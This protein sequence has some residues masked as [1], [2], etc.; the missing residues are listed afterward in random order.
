MF[1]L[2]LFSNLDE[3]YAVQ[4]DRTEYGIISWFCQKTHFT[5]VFTSKI[6]VFRVTPYFRFSCI[7]NSFHKDFISCILGR[8]S[9]CIFERDRYPWIPWISMDI[10]GVHGY[11]WT[12]MDIHGYPWIPWISMD[13]MDI[14][15]FHGYPWMASQGKQSRRTPTNIF[16]RVT[17][18]KI[19]SQPNKSNCYWDLLFATRPEG[20]RRIF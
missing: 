5:I 19:V 18:K 11:P 1:E 4:N 6:S 20:G 3:D 8:D 10:H 12:S 2:V 9:S 7:I 16:G 17:V 15:G 14:H 13:S